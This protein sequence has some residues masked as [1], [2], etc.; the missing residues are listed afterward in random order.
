MG[1]IWIEKYLFQQEE[2][3]LQLLHKYQ[4]NDYWLK[5]K[6]FLHLTRRELSL[7]RVWMWGTRIY[8][9]SLLIILIKLVKLFTAAILTSVSASFN[10]VVNIWIRE[11]SV[12][13]LPKASASWKFNSM[14][15]NFYLSEIFGQSKSDFPRF[16]FSC[17][18]D[19]GKSMCF[20]LFFIQELGNLL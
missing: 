15:Q 16:V 17:S 5:T 11:M 1:I 9:L 14:D 12:I 10:S 4:L 13:S 7:A 2:R 3:Q 19:Y 8:N 6:G 20:I 18:N